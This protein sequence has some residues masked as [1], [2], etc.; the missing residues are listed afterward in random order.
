M[1][2]PKGIKLYMIYLE[3]NI[4]TSSES[5]TFVLFSKPI[6]MVNLEKIDFLSQ[7]QLNYEFLK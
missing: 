6:S 1:Y 2:A 5:C 7:S 4:D 3:K